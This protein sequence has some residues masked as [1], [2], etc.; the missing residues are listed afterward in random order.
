MALYKKKSIFL[1][2]KVLCQLEMKQKC[3][4]YSNPFI[5][6]NKPHVFGTIFLTTTF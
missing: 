2:L 4:T 1:H 3:V 6:L 5:A